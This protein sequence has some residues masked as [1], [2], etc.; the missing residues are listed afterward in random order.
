MY[1]A[2]N[3][4]LTG[5]SYKD[6]IRELFNI[7]LYCSGLYRAAFALARAIRSEII[8]HHFKPAVKMSK[9][10]AENVSPFALARAIRSEIIRHHF[11]PA[12]KMS[13]ERAENVSV[14]ATQGAGPARGK[15]TYFGDGRLQS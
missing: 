10:R 11:K 2:F 1:K 15:V 6:R 9:E 12:V 13:K 5:E 14:S 8:R 3:N 4:F 7:N